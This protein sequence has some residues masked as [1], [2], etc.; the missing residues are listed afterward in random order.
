LRRSPQRS[1]N[2][3]DSRAE[4]GQVL[5]LNH[6]SAMVDAALDHGRTLD[7]APL[8]VA[9]LDQGGHLLVLK[10]Q[11]GSGIL[12]PQIAQAKAWGALGMGTRQP[13]V[14]RTRGHR[15]GVLHR[16]GRHFRRSYRA[17]PGRVLVR[18]S[19]APV[20]GG[21]LSAT[22]RAPPSRR[23]ASAATTPPT[24]RTARC[25]ASSPSALPRTQ[26]EAAITRLGDG[27]ANRVGFRTWL[28]APFCCS[29]LLRRLGI[30]KM[31]NRTGTRAVE[32]EKHS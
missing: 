7:G 12:R 8:T 24:T 13:S 11:D 25:S 10:R 17:G 31:Q 15:P 18:D 21:C 29:V 32:Q 26:A 3:S 2:R 27:Q 5:S 20:P 28:V 14:G 9:V 19:I 4:A 1:A 23:S 22:A 16:T 30:W 6:A